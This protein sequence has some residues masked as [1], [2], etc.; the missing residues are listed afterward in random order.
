MILFQMKDDFITL[1]KNSKCDLRVMQIKLRQDQALT[2]MSRWS[3][4]IQHGEL[5]TKIQL[6][7][8]E[9]SCSH[10]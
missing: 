4:I 5:V 9:R 2:L 7:T 8:K 1:K 6:N 3:Q 10:C